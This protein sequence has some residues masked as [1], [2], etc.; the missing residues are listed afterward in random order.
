MPTPPCNTRWC[1]RSCAFVLRWRARARR[2]LRCA[3]DA[4]RRAKAEHIFEVHGAQSARL[5][6]GEPIGGEAKDGLAR[7]AFYAD[8]LVLGQHDPNDATA[9]DVPA[10]LVQNLLIATGKPALVLPYA[11]A[12]SHTRP[13]G[14]TALLAWKET[15]EAAR[16]VAAALPGLVRAR[17]VHIVS[18]GAD[19]AASVARLVRQLGRH[20][21][22]AGAHAAGAER[23][24]IGQDLL[25]RAGDLGADLLV[26]GCYGHS[27]LREMVLG[28]MSRTVLQSMA[29]PVLMVH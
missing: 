14:A 17:Q 13:L 19:T 10:D 25:A 5:S 15:P 2:W 11:S 20:G 7:R 23:G 27:R 26:M 9:D 1:R 18:Y 28:D 4:T 29:Q 22:T 21:V 12:P 8:L 3:L 16:A 24:D 6:W